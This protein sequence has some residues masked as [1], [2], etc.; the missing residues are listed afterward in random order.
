MPNPLYNEY[1]P[2]NIQNGGNIV[3]QFAEFRKN[4]NGDPKQMVQQLL[5]SGK[6]TQEQYN[7]AVQKASALRQMFGV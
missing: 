6:I 3:Q 4:F 5:S 7:Q 1:G 2:R